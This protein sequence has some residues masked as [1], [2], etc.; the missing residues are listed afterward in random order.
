MEAGYHSDQERSS[1]MT[2][3]L[4]LREVQE[5]TIRMFRRRSFY[6]DGTAGANIHAWCVEGQQDA[7]G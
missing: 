2:F 3:G 1:K 5:V 4:L 6:V 7:V